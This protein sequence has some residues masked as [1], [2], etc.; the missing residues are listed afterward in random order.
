MR[1][2]AAG[3]HFSQVSVFRLDDLISSIAMESEITRSTQLFTRHCFHKSHVPSCDPALN[4][5]CAPTEQ[6]HSLN[7]DETIPLT[8]C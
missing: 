7:A 8:Q 4:R 5:Y 1:F 2:I 6:F 3:D